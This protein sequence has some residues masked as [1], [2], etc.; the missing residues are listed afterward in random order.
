MHPATD[1]CVGLAQPHCMSDCLTRVSRVISPSVTCTKGQL[2]ISLEKG[3]STAKVW[4][5]HSPPAASIGDLP[6]D[7]SV[8]LP[9]SDTGL[10][11]SASSYSISSVNA[12]K[13][14]KEKNK[15]NKVKASW[16][17]SSYS[18]VTADPANTRMHVSYR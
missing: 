14:K 12:E 3:K 8:T 13:K 10:I 16:S 4:K 7:L 2:L 11:H 6:S 15:Q 5:F 18:R 9:A 17:V 1:V